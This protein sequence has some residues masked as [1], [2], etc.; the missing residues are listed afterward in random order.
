MS[1][2]WSQWWAML[3]LENKGNKTQIPF[4]RWHHKQLYVS[5]NLLYTINFI[6]LKNTSLSDYVPAKYWP[7]GLMVILITKLIF[8]LLTAI[9]PYT[10]IY[11]YLPYCWCSH[12]LW[13]W[14]SDRPGMYHTPTIKFMAITIHQENV[15]YVI[16]NYGKNYLIT[17]LSLPA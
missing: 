11:G 12:C 7:Q 15:T 14:V 13:V 3:S 2:A 6:H 1:A 4:H 17:A 8:T 16:T 10:A 5:S 9:M